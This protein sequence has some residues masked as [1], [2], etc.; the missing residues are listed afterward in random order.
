MID[1]CRRLDVRSARAQGMAK[2]DKKTLPASLCGTQN[3][4]GEGRSIEQRADTPSV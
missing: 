3:D 4:L 2:A 1:Q